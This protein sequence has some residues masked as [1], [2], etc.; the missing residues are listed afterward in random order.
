MNNN[1]TTKNNLDNECYILKHVDK[2]YT[3]SK[4]NMTSV[5]C[6]QLTTNACKM[7][8]MFIGF[9]PCSYGYGQIYGVFKYKDDRIFGFK[10]NIHRPKQKYASLSNRMTDIFEYSIAQKYDFPF[11]NREEFTE[12]GAEAFWINTPT[13]SLTGEDYD[14]RILMQT[15]KKWAVKEQLCKKI[16]KSDKK[17]MNWQNNDLESED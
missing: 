16:R 11:V 14:L 12:F 2:V 15:I 4:L 8:R 10:W 7:L 6:E 17:Y 5:P 9:D 1:E 3:G 13:K